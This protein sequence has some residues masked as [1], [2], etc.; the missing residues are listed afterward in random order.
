[1]GGKKYILNLKKLVISDRIFEVPTDI[2]ILVTGAER[3]IVR[4]TE[5]HK[6]F[7]INCVRKNFLV[8]IDTTFQKTI[9]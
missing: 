6:Q 7:H 8:K 4:S 1:M 9:Q 2:Q 3:Q 5:H